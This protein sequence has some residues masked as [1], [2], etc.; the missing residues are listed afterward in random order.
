MPLLKRATRFPPMPAL[1][2]SCQPLAMA[3]CVCHPNP[4]WTT[5]L[6]P[7][8]YRTLG[9]P[10]C[11][12]A[13]FPPQACGSLRSARSTRYEVMRS[14]ERAGRSY[15]VR[16]CCR[17]HRPM[18]ERAWLHQ[19][20]QCNRVWTCRQPS[21]RINPQRRVGRSCIAHATFDGVLVRHIVNHQ[22][23]LTSKSALVSW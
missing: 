13:W 9:P 14:T 22:L 6:C 2:Q 8:R 21:A 5:D 23:Q 16:R 20:L 7:S 1:C 15:L 11:Q 17:T 19:R 10:P 4:I 12:I 3:V 18:A